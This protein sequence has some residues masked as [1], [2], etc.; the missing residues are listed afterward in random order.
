MRKLDQ[1]GVAA[2]EFC[3]VG[4]TFLTLVFAIFDL[5]RYAITNQ[6]LRALV[7]AGARQIMIDCYTPAAIQRTTPACSG[8]PL[9]SD[10]AK[11]NIAP[12]SFVGAL[13][14]T[15][16]AATGGGVVAVTASQPNFTMMLPIWGTALDKPSVST[17]IP[18]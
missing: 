8:D 15:L 2:L 4:A 11:K 5:A 18:Y 17:N 14:P 6:S 16:S 9:P 12:L 1:R 10:A 3:L 13:A 7:N